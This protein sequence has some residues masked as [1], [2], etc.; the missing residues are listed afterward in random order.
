MAGGIADLFDSY[1]RQAR[2]FPGLLTVFPPLTVVLAWFPMLLLSNLGTALLTLATSC[3]LLYALGSLART[4]GKN[5]EARLLKEW[6]G[7]PTTINLRFSGP[8][9]KPTLTRYHGFLGRNV[10]GLTMPSEDEERGNPGAADGVYASAVKWLKEETRKGFPLV[11]KENA[12]YGFRRNLRGMRPIGI[13]S[14]VAAVVFSLV[15]IVGRP[16]AI[17]REALLQL[18][19]AQPPAIWAAIATCVVALV[20]WFWIVNDGWVRQ[21]GNQYA[22][23]LLAACDRLPDKR[24]GKRSG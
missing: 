4:L 6:G 8:L 11:D 16:P 12:Q 18:A 3:G 7:W 13:L 21:A 24:K 1:A 9:E 5:V 15:A 23:A 10:P 14:C 17:S 19:S 22:D 20:G 2:L